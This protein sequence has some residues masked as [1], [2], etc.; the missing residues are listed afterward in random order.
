MDSVL[1]TCGL[2]DRHCSECLDSE[3]VDLYL[4][5]GSEQLKSYGKAKELGTETQVCCLC[6]LLGD[7]GRLLTFLNFSDQLAVG[8]RGRTS[9]F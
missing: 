4:W 5:K 8:D 7:L 6:W 3:L 2:N 1:L 9:I